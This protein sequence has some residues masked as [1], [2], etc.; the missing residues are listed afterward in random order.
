MIIA[1]QVL[2]LMQFRIVHFES[3]LFNEDSDNNPMISGQVEY[4]DELHNEDVLFINCENLIKIFIRK[5]KIN[6]LLGSMPWRIRVYASE[7]T[8]KFL[9]GIPL[10]V[11]TVLIEAPRAVTWVKTL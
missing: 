1:G 5:F 8:D 4:H 11:L 2:E 6:N 7:I 10:S 3:P 9:V